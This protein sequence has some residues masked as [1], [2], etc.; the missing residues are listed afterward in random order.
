M[1][2]LDPFWANIDRQ[3]AELEE[4]KTAD[5]VLRICPRIP[6]VS[7]GHGFFEGSGGDKTVDDAL[8]T[9]G[10]TVVWWGASYHWRMR[11]PDAT[12]ITYIEGD[13]YRGRG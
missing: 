7:S 6:D 10:W 1:S 11:A 12:E 4:A 13:L 3:I 5:D 8:R 9:A 2:K